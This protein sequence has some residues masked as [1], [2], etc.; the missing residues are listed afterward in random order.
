MYI[1]YLAEPAHVK[2]VLKIF[3]ELAWRTSSPG[4]VSHC[5]STQTTVKSKPARQL[6]APCSAAVDQLSTCLADVEGWLKAIRLR[7]NPGKTQF[8]WL[9]SHQLLSKLDIGDVSVLSARI[10]VQETARDFGVVID[11]RLTLSDHVAVAQQSV[12]AATINYDNFVRPSGAR[13]MLSRL[14]SPVACTIVMFCFMASPSNWFATCRQ[15][16]TPPGGW[17]RA[18]GGLI[19]IACAPPAALA[20]GAGARRVQG[21]DA[22]IYQS[23]SGH[24]PGYLVDDCQLV[25][26]VS[27][28]CVL[29]TLGRLLSTGRPAVSET[30]PTQLLE[31]ECGTVCRQT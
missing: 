22:C 20:S 19:I 25:T 2:E 29:L 15:F 6:S 9:G 16:K 18:L 28:I 12:E 21:R 11:S 4:T 5:I 23:L 26:F 8:M 1:L 7:L 30:G 13:R 10:P 17:L 3:L 31:P 27:D 24:A 14:S